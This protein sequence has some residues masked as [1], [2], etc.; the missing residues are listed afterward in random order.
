MN[1]CGSSLVVYLSSGVFFVFLN[2][3]WVLEE[4]GV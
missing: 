1:F 4:L 3:S 2:V